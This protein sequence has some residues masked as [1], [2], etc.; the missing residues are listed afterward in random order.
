MIRNYSDKTPKLC[1]SSYSFSRRDVLKLNYKQNVF[2][3]HSNSERSDNLQK[4]KYFNLFLHV[5]P[6]ANGWYTTKYTRAR[7]L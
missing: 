7:D 2:R 4:N 1:K 5:A 3:F 6:T